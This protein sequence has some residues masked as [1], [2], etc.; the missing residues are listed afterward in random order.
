MMLD[1]EGISYEREF[2]FASPRKWRADF[3]IGARLLVE[4]E[5]VT[6]Y[7]AIGRHQS[8]KGYAKDCEKYNAAAILGYT[9]LR[10][11]TGMVNDGSASKT[12]QEYLSR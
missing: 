1:R 6:S 11:T 2:V 7:G 3:H 9:V 8:A 10:F 12:I 4:V 5:G